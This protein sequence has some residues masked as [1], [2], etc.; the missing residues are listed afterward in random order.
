VAR[1]RAQ[2]A[3]AQQPDFGRQLSVSP[4]ACRRD[5]HRCEIGGPF[6]IGA[7]APGHAAPQRLGQQLAEDADADRI[8]IGP[9][10]AGIARLRL[11]LVDAQPRRAQ[12]HRQ[13]RR[14]A[15]RI[16]QPRAM[17]R[18]PQCAVVAILRIGDDHRAHQPCALVDIFRKGNTMSTMADTTK[19]RRPRRRFDE[20]FKAQAVRLVLDEGKPVTAVAHD[21]D[22]TETALREWVKRARADRTHGRTG[23][24]T[25]EREELA[26]LRK[27][28]REL[29]TE[30]EI[31]KKA[32]VF[33]AKHQA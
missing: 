6:G 10:L 28:N 16:R 3:F 8:L 1:G 13:R 32:A 15:E 24:T 7:V 12:K 26:R 27:E 11:L 21:L 29:R 23:L 9:A 19:T 14:D 18:L 20:D 31:L 33:F 17:Q 2:A 25:A 4:V 22:L 30:R 5:P